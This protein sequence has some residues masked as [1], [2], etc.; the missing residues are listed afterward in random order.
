MR[1]I[2]EELGLGPEEE[3]SANLNTTF[4]T[5]ILEKSKTD[6]EIYKEDF[7][8]ARST[9]LDSI[10]SSKVLLEFALK[11]AQSTE[12]ARSLEIVD[13]I[14]KGL[15]SSS[16]DLLEAHQK[17]R[18][19]DNSKVKEEKANQINVDKAVFVGTQKEL[20]EMIKKTRDEDTS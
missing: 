15:V 13:A 8:Y 12:S 11:I 1:N 7:E 18:R 14:L 6:E 5:R 17:R 2:D 9:I 3:P 20:L 19:F 4:V 16:N 10:D